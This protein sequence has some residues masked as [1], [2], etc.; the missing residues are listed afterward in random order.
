MSDVA[1]RDWIERA[2]RVSVRA[3]LTRRG[4]WDQR[5]MSGDRGV[6]C[7]GCG[8]TDR[9]AVNLRKN[10][11]LCRVSGAAGGAIALAQHIDGTDFLTACETVTGEPRPSGGREESPGDK[12]AREERVTRERLREERAQQRRLVDQAQY[13]ERE[14]GEAYA[15]WQERLPIAGTL[16]EAALQKRGLVA[17]PEA[18]VGFLA[19]THLWNY[20]GGRIVHSGPA[21]AWAIEGPDGRFAGLQRIWIDL[22]DPEG[23]ARIPDPD[24]PG[25]MVAAKKVRGSLKGGSILWARASHGEQ[26]T[27]DGGQETPASDVCHPYSAQHLWLAEG[28]ENAGS[29]HNWLQAIESPLLPLSEFRATVSLSNLAGKAAGR[30]RHPS[31]TRTDRLGRQRPHFVGNSEPAPDDDTP[32]VPIGEATT[33]LWLIRDGDSEPFFT[34]MAIGRAA[35]RY[36]A[37]YPWLTIHVL[38]AEPGRD[39]NEQWLKQLGRAA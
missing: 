15:I 31:L 29:V 19:H 39:I 30:A 27:E 32:L 33:H 20:P 9:F 4:L 12:R 2:K 24:R 23:K 25:A 36:G 3:E 37:A 7:P 11:F 21:L 28:I 14:R 8:G 17:P 26:R 35:K 18:R 10:V 13:R 6:P 34:E 5:K 16:G 22:N 1:F 38:A